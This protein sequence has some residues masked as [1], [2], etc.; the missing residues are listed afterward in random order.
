[1]DLHALV[2]KCLGEGVVF[3]AR[4]LGPEHVV[5]EQV[6]DVARGEPGQFQAGPVHDD[7]A[8]LADF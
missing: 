7:L 4:L 6:R 5:E 1:M 8:Q 3:L 2:T